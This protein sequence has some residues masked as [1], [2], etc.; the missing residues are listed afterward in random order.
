VCICFSLA[1]LMLV[2]GQPART[3]YLALAGL[4]LLWLGVGAALV[5]CDYH[6]FTDVVAGWALS[7]LLI[8]LTFW[9]N[10]AGRPLVGRPL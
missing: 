3:R 4:A 1:V 2:A 6:W 9:I 7:A 5:W 8:Q 10:R